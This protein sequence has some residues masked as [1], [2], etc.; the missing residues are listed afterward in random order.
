MPLESIAI[1]NFEKNAIDD[2]LLKTRLEQLYDSS[3]DFDNGE[4]AIKVFEK[5]FGNGAKLYVGMFNARPIA[6]LLVTDDGIDGQR[7]LQNIV[8]HTANRGRGIA[9]KLI[10][11][12]TDLERKQGILNFV[13]NDVVIQ[14]ILNRYELG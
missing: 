8:V 13:G 6:A 11:Q 3:P 10:K 7:R 12:V 5:W 1:N 4:T 9:A 2:P 14:L